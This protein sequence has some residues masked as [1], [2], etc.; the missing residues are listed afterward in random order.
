MAQVKVVPR[1]FNAIVHRG[2]GQFLAGFCVVLDLVKNPRITNR[3]AA[4]HNAV[5]AI[6]FLV[7]NRLFHRINI[8][9]AKNRHGDARVIFHAGNVRPIGFPFVELCARTSVNRQACTP[10]SCNLSATS[11]ILIEFHPNPNASLP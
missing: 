2:H 5:H 9:I 6:S 1:R 4:N 11:S 3:R 7:L 10:M 8:T